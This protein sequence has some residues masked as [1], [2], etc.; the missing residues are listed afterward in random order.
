MEALFVLST[1]QNTPMHDLNSFAAIANLV[2][3]PTT[4]PL[5]QKGKVIWLFGLSGAGKSTLAQHT[6]KMLDEE[7]YFSVL[8]DG[9][10]LRAGINKDLGFSDKDRMENIRRAAQIARLLAENNIIAICS[11]ITPMA[12]HRELVKN[13][14]GN[15]YFGVYVSCPLEICEERDV[16]GLYKKARNQQIEN[17]TGIQGRFDIPAAADLVIRTDQ[18]TPEE[19]AKKL[20]T[21]FNINA[22]R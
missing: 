17:F 14:A 7:G 12:E 9:D 4:G 3:I 18:E 19:S 20:L 6:K 13:I 16:K 10:E 5:L 1:L 15:Y 21:I 2:N 11:F 8:L 22:H